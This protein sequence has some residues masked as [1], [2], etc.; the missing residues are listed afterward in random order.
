MITNRPRAVHQKGPGAG[1]FAAGP[2]SRASATPYLL[3]E[4]DIIPWTS[5]DAFTINALAGAL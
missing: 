3:N 5:A 1:G 4:F 2:R